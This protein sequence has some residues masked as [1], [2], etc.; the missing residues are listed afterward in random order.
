MAIMV[1]LNFHNFL[2]ALGQENCSIWPKTCGQA[3]RI[4]Q[5]EH[6]NVFIMGLPSDS[7][8]MPGPKAQVQ[9]KMNHTC[10]IEGSNMAARC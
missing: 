1:R 5:P 10:A 6:F 3:P 7:N 4:T 8:E 2:S 9:H